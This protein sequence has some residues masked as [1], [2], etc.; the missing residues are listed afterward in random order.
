[1]LQ[2]KTK[3]QMKK[4]DSLITHE[5]YSKSLNKETKTLPNVNGH[6]VEI[7]IKQSKKRTQKINLSNFYD[8]SYFSYLHN[9]NHYY[10]AIDPISLYLYNLYDACSPME[11]KQR[12]TSNRINKKKVIFYFL[13]N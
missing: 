5:R 2:K 11:R 1:M 13:K 12:K 3:I 9:S 6:D 10:T 7:K 8:N 4:E